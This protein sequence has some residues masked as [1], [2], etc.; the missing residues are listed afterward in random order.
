[1]LTACPLPAGAIGRAY[2]QQLNASGGAAPYAWTIAGSLPAGLQLASNGQLSGTPSAAGPSL[3]RL[4]ATDAKGSAVGSQCSLAVVRPPL[5][6]D[7][8]P[9][10]PGSVGQSYAQ[11][12]TAVG[13]ASPYLW[14]VD[15]A[16]PAGLSYSTYGR[17]SGTPTAA[18]QYSFSLRTVDAGGQ[19]VSQACSVSIEAALPRVTTT[20]PLPAGEVGKNYSAPINAQ[21][22]TPPYRW[23][24]DGTLPP[25]LS[26][27]SSG[28][29]SGVPSQAGAYSFTLLGTDARNHALSQLCAVTIA[30]P[31]VPTLRV[32]DIAA[33]VAPA[34]SNIATGVELSEAYSQPLQGTADAQRG[35]ANRLGCRRQ[36]GRSDRAVPQ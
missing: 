17:I 8:C 9:L 31:A 22:G 23:F 2:S 35:A 21:G 27:A 32:S 7:S 34:T 15:G 33:T 19:A 29:L 11:D 5:S 4:I 13:G 28:T 25:D 16:L 26:L 20:C 3:F 1:M 30:L 10:P 24:T 36:R 12:L 18:G 6:I 14:S